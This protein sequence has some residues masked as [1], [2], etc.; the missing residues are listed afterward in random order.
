MR[1]LVYPP[2][3]NT[4]VLLHNVVKTKTGM[5]SLSDFSHQTH[6]KDPLC[7]SAVK[8]ITCFR[9]NLPLY[10]FLLQMAAVISCQACQIEEHTHLFIFACECVF[11]S[12]PI[13][14]GGWGNPWSGPLG[15]PRAWA[16]LGNKH[17]HTWTSH[18]V[19]TK[20]ES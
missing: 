16:P 4:T 19:W 14:E 15:Q 2:V 7:L 1:T 6:G 12:H 8:N 11:I 18:L 9:V 17:T 5:H 3:I 13:E 20:R 10:S